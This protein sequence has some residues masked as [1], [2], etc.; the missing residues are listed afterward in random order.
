LDSG[1]KINNMEME[2]SIGLMGLFFKENLIKDIKFMES[3]NGPMEL[4]IK[5]NF[6]KVNYKEKVYLLIKMVDIIQVNGIII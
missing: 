3:F 5:D 6:I 4:N 1:K 2:K